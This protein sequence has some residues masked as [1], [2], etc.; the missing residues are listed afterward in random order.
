MKLLLLCVS[1]LLGETFEFVENFNALDFDKWEKISG[2]WVAINDT[3][4]G[5]VS[6]GDGLLF[7]KDK[8][9]KDF[10]LECKINVE[11]R[12][13]SI[14]F[15]TLDK[16][17]SYILV[18]SP[19][20]NKDIQGSLLLIKRIK[21]RETYFA[22]AEQYVPLKTWIKIKIITEGKKIDIYS[23]DN[24]VLS[25]EDENLS[26]GKVGLRIFGDFLSPSIAY[27]KDFSIKVVK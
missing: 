18:F 5:S 26:E 9:F 15:R 23:N 2:D 17:N 6:G 13:G 16:N 3:L 7:L 25:V 14:A 19:K 10:I 1:L 24:F 22:G 4:K 8:V 20:I 27:Y 11:N 21:G 12:E